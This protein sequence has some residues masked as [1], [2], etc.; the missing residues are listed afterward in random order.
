M[1]SKSFCLISLTTLPWASLSTRVSSESITLDVS[2]VFSSRLFLI[3]FVASLASAKVLKSLLESF[4][5]T[6]FCSKPKAVGSNT[7]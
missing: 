1:L 5:N 6:K 2:P 4:L 7:E 3:A